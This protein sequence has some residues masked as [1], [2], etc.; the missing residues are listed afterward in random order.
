MQILRTPDARFAAL[1]DYSFAPRY[2]EL[3][4]LRLHYV[5]EGP[6]DAE[7]V[8]LLHGVECRRSR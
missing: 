6:P 2:V 5:D 8:L 3:E 1:P 7:P 4:R